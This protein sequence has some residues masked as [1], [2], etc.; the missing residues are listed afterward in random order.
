[1]TKMRTNNK[2]AWLIFI[3][4]L[5]VFTLN[6]SPEF[7]AFQTRFA[8]FAQEMLHHGISWFPSTYQHPYPDYPVLPT[9]LIYLLALITGKI[10]PLVAILPTAITSALIL[11]FI[12]RF[13]AIWKERWGIYAVLFALFTQYFVQESRSIALDQYISLVTIGCIYIIHSAKIYNL[14]KRLWLLP[15][16]LIGG[17]ACRGPIGL[18]I[19]ASVC[20]G[21]F[22]Y[23]RQFKQ[24]FYW[25]LT[26][27]SLLLISMLALLTAAYLQAGTP[28][29]HQVIFM[30]IVG[31]IATANKSYWYYLIC[32]FT[33]YAI[34][35]PIAIITLIVLHKTIIKPQTKSQQSLGILACWL[36]IILIGMSIPAEKKVRY[37]LA[38]VP[39]ISLIAAY[40]YLN[41]THN[42]N[43]Y[44][45]KKILYYFCKCF[46]Y[47][48]LVLILVATVFAQ[49]HNLHLTTNVITATIFII[50]LILS[51]RRIKRHLK[52]LHLH[53]LLTISLAV[54]T[55]L[56]L[57]IQILNPIQYQLETT[58]PFVTAFYELQK[59]QPAKLVFYA[60]GPDAEDI[61][62]AANLKQPPTPD[63]IHTQ[64][65]LKQYKANA[66][67]I[68]KAETFATLPPQLKSKLELLFQGKIGHK[69]CVIFRKKLQSRKS[70]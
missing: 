69:K 12:Y 64:I 41:P 55:F 34:S 66:Y 46:P 62:F 48:A 10:T 2:T 9:I 28:F 15:L 65:Q 1:M 27:V 51:A 33:S 23:L 26:T 58:L 38:I 17:F 60:L 63:F 21:Y 70:T 14:N 54:L 11:V 49:T 40:G 45:L 5:I 39:A 31:R 16:I 53:D 59:I 24:L 4:G 50:I 29:L 25:V 68:T 61:K 42:R 43:L 3:F 36:G 7:I 37:I 18:I 30:Q 57:N 6:L 44:Y 32:G 47:L 52:S 22:L 19:P 20:G 8:L 13:G 56:L 35:F 67:F